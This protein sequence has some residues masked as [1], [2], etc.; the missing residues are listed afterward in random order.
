METAHV[1]VHMVDGGGGCV[2]LA[3]AKTEPLVVPCQYLWSEIGG[4]GIGVRWRAQAAPW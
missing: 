3:G 1:A 2:N 4:R